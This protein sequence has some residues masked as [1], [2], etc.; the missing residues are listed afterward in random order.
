MPSPIAIYE[1]FLYRRHSG[2]GWIERCLLDAYPHAIQ[3]TD[4]VVLRNFDGHV[5]CLRGMTDEMAFYR[6]PFYYPKESAILA[7]V[8]GKVIYRTTWE[9]ITLPASIINLLPRADAIVVP[10]KF[11]RDIVLQQFSCVYLVPDPVKPFRYR[12]KYTRTYRIGGMIHPSRRRNLD[13]W[14]KLR[15]FLPTRFKIA[16]VVAPEVAEDEKL[17]AFVR[18][19]ADEVLLNIDDRELEEFYAS[20]DWFVSLSVGEGYGLPVREALKVGTPVICGRHTGY[21]DLDGFSGVVFAQSKAKEGTEFGCWHGFVLAPEPKEIARLIATTEP[22]AVPDNLPL[23]TVDDFIASFHQILKPDEPVERRIFAHVKSTH[24]VWIVPNANP[25]GVAEA[26]RL[27]AKRTGGSVLTISEALSGVRAKAVIIAYHPN[28]WEWYRWFWASLVRKTRAPI[29]LWL[30]RKPVHDDEEVTL[31]SVSD[32]IWA[33]TERLRELVGGH[34]VLH[35]PIGD[36][37][38]GDAEPDLFGSF[39]IYKHETATLLNELGR[40]L[41]SKRFLGLWSLSP[42]FRDEQPAQLLQRAIDAAPS[43]VTHLIGPFSSEELHSY[44]S[45]MAGYILWNPPWA[46]AGESSARIALVLRMNRPILTNDDSPM[47]E[48]YRRYIPTLQR[49]DPEF[50]TTLLLRPLDPYVPTK[51]PTLEEE[52]E[53]FKKA[54]ARVL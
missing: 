7:T 31:T 21:L 51:V 20:L 52:L 16:L 27:W 13:G 11:L 38:I 49:F 17:L 34:A 44:L 53:I 39:G 1:P 37:P 25:C 23:P 30:H 28:F 35:N 26:A 43:N 29:I 33:T 18:E 45:S 2:Y 12:K 50:L 5:I 47:V 14:R 36:P 54:I 15:E 46:A 19:L 8:K 41:P 3:V 22:P 10:S 48:P 9:F 24:V 32:A 40:R 6:P 4:P 42:Y